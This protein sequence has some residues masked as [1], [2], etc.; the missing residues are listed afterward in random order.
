MADRDSVGLFARRVMDAQ[1]RRLSDLR[2]AIRAAV[3]ELIAGYPDVWPGNIDSSWCGVDTVDLE[4]EV[5]GMS[6]GWSLPRPLA[7]LLLSD[8]REVSRMAFE[9]LWLTRPPATPD[10]DLWDL[11][12]K[13]EPGGGHYGK[14]FS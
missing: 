10:R 4:I 7:I 12:H 9:S 3:I 14:S 11:G 5:R 1:E 8:D 13:L 6:I 2:V